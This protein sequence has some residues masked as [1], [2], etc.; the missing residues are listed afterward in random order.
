MIISNFH[1]FSLS[2]SFPLDT[3]RLTTE[4]TLISFPLLSLLFI[5]R[6]TV[7]QTKFIR[8]QKENTVNRNASTIH[9]ILC[10]TNVAFTTHNKNVIS[11][12]SAENYGVFRLY[13][14]NLWHIKYLKCK[15]ITRMCCFIWKSIEN[16]YM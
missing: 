2:L 5:L 4:S 1:V 11:L 8:K 7:R 15:E 10:T 6:L 3:F 14:N 9:V 12:K 13:M 16:S